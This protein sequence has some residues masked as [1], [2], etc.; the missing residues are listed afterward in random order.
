MEDHPRRG[1]T[2]ARSEYIEVVGA[3]RVFLYGLLSMQT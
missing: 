3:F 1:A 2:F